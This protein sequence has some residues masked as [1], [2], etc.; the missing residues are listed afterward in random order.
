MP[1]PTGD[2]DQLEAIAANFPE[3]G[4]AKEIHDAYGE[5]RPPQRTLQYW[6]SQLVDAAGWRKSVGIV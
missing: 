4:S 1:R 6:L 5:P 3:G 2:L